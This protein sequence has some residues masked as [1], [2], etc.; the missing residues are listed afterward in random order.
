MGRSRQPRDPR[1]QLLQSRVGMP[2][3]EPRLLCSGGQLSGLPSGR[4]FHPL[5]SHDTT[6]V[7]PHDVRTQQ[8]Q[9]PSSRKQMKKKPKTAPSLLKIQAPAVLGA[10]PLGVSAVETLGRRSHFIVTRDRNGIMIT[11][12][13]KKQPASDGGP[14]RRCMPPVYLAP[15][16][17]SPA[18][19]FGIRQPQLAGTS[20]PDLFT[21][22]GVHCSLAIGLIIDLTASGPNLVQQRTILN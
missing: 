4:E 2:L 13:G 15:Q 12:S 19:G 5:T 7:Q 16:I 9:T 17:R 10:I 21:L 22:C 6:H 11:N 20:K 1:W 18:H 14:P 3:G 8:L